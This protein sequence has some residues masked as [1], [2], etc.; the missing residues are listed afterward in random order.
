[1]QEAN[2]LATELCLNYDNVTFIETADLFLDEHGEPN[3][4]LYA[5][6]GLHLSEEGYAAWT[7]RIK[8]LLK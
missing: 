4:K 8:P 2:R 6:D 5:F 3:K 1:V 7:S